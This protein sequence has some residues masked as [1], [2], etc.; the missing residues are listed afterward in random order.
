MRLSKKLAIAAV[1]TVATVGIAT[2]AFA[3]W[4]QS[5][6]G[7]GTASAGSTTNVTVNQ[8]S[9]ISG[10]YPGGSPV[11]LSGDFSNPNSGPV[12]VGSVTVVV[13][14]NW[15]ARADSTKPACT[16]DDFSIGG[17]ALVNA[18]IASATHTGSWTGLT[19]KLNDGSGNQDNCKNASAALVYSVSPAA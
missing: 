5:G 18:E 7:S 6:G 8:T 3:Y 15:S 2:S 4:T 17:S 13:D 1:S 9:T 12:K 16:A 11:T 14:P 10:L 19:I